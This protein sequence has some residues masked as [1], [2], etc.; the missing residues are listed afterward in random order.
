M[1]KKKKKTEVGDDDFD[2]EYQRRCAVARSS[3]CVRVSGLF[4][5]RVRVRVT[6]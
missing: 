4:C 6:C 3:L 2:Y 1:R 5:C